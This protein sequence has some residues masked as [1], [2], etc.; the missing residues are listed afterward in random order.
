VPACGVLALQGGWQAHRLA[1]DALGA[2]SLPVRTASD[3]D[4]VECLVMP[5]GESSA[6]L[7]LMEGSDLGNRIVERIAAGMPVLATCAGVILLATAVVPEQPS[8]GA[9]SIEIVRNAYGRQVVSSVEEIE[10]EPPLGPPTSM[11]AV[12]IRAPRIV[13]V[14]P[15]VE[16][17]GSWRGD[18]VVIRQGNILGA[19]FH[20]E[21][22]ADRRIH[23]LFLRRGEDRNG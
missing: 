3:L 5:G 13:K 22:T 6:M 17:L 21:L 18:P 14:G 8:L 10:V 2:E 15:G 4:T 1:L 20:P 11:E 23:E 16:V 7:R 12:F 19:T 9:L